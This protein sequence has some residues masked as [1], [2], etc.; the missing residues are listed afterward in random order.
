[1]T[2][3]ISSTKYFLLLSLLG[4]HNEN[5]AFLP[6]LCYP[7]HFCF[8]PLHQEN[9]AIHFLYQVHLLRFIHLF[10]YLLISNFPFFS[11]NKDLTTLSLFLLRDFCLFFYQ[12]PNVTYLFF[13]DLSVGNQCK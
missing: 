12:W 5:K 13:T 4:D 7:C 9:V 11:F 6:V 1:M 3:F 10:I 8:F 2:F